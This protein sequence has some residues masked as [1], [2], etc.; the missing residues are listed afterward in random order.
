MKRPEGMT[1]EQCYDIPAC[2]CK[3]ADDFTM[4]ITK[5]ELT[6]E[7]LAII[8][9]TKSIFLGIIG[10]SMPPVFLEVKNLF[11]NPSEMN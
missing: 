1:E 4:V 8:I 11:Y 5:W 2:I 3:S 6:E 9:K 7:E 10:D